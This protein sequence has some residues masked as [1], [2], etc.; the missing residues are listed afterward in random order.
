[1][2][3][4]QYLV[5]GSTYQFDESD[6]PKGAVLVETKASKTPANK[7]RA[8]STKASKTPAKAPAKGAPATKSENPE[9]PPAT[10]SD[11]VEGASDPSASE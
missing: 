10:S 6:A 4:K 5:N 11:G 3:L 8:A 9:T 7:A 1:M 2:G